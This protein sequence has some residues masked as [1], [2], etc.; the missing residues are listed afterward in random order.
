MEIVMKTGK[1]LKCAYTGVETQVLVT[2]KADEG[3]V[4]AGQLS[5]DA[6]VQALNFIRAYK[7]SMGIAQ[8][9]PQLLT[10]VPVA[11]VQP[12]SRSPQFVS[13]QAPVM[14]APTTAT[15]T[16]LRDPQP[17]VEQFARAV[18]DL[19]NNPPE[20]NVGKQK[21]LAEIHVRELISKWKTSFR[22]QLS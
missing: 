16:T 19:A 2:L 9:Q 8:A 22:Y 11:P 3:G 17:L 4:S 1:D 20:D 7:Q 15:T 13:Q 5:E 12:V 10:E 18:V 21:G 14:S 6:L